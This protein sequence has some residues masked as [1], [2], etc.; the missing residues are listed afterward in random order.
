MLSLT[1]LFGLNYDFVIEEPVLQERMKQEFPINYKTML[2]TFH[3]SDP[4]LQLDGDKQRF[5]FTGRLQIPD[6][7]DSSGKAVSAIVSVSSRIAYSKGG[8]LYLRNI[9][10]VDIKSRYIGADMKSMLYGAV[11][12][13][14]NDYFKSRAIYSLEKEKGMVGAVVNSIE[15]VIIVKEGV[16]IIFNAG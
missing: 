9:K 12:Q 4:K 15:N 16:K 13:L 6:I 10:V 1:S 7:K 11:D 5:N 2:L 8:N 14:L 3:I